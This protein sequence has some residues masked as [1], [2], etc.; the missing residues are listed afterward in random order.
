MNAEKCE[1]KIMLLQEL[2]VTTF[3]LCFMKTSVDCQE[4]DI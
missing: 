3:R 2:I 1:S 4:V